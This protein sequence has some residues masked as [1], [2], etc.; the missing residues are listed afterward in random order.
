MLFSTTRCDCCSLPVGGT[1]DFCP[2]CG[3]PVDGAKE[4]QFLQSS[5]ASL[6]RVAVYGGAHMT[7][8]QLIE[9]YRARLHYLTQVKALPAGQTAQS[10]QKAPVAAVTPVSAPAAQQGNAPLPVAAGLAQTQSVPA[11]SASNQDVPGRSFSLG[12]FLE[13]QTITVVAALGAFLI[14]VGALSFVA[15]TPNL[16]LSFLVVFVVH[17][18][19]GVIGMI[20]YRYR[21]FRAVAVIYTAI[22]ALL[23]PLVGFSAY[24]VVSGSMLQ[25]STSTLVAIAALYAALAY[26]VL[27]VYQ[28]F[29]PFAYLAVVALALATLATASALRLGYWWWPGV[30]M[31]LALPA[32][33]SV[34]RVRGDMRPFVEPWTILREPLLVFM[35]ACVVACVVG[36]PSVFAYSLLLDVSNHART[37]VRLALSCMALLLFC[38]NFLLVWRTKRGMWAVALPYLFL[39][40]IL[41]GAY[42]LTFSRVGYV[43]T[44][45]GVALLYHGLTRFVPRVMQM[46]NG[47]KVHSEWL[48]LFLVALVPFLIMSPFLLVERA[49][50]SGFQKL[51]V[52][53]ETL[54][55]LSAVLLGL[56][57]TISVVFSHTG[58][59][60]VPQT[61]QAQWCW[62][63]LLSGF[64]LN[65]AFALFL[66]M[67]NAEPVWWL[68]GLSL[69]LV[70]TTILI[71]RF[72]SSTW[73]RPLDVLALVEIVLALLLGFNQRLELV[74]AMWLGVALLLYG[75][76]LY[77]RRAYV[78][79]LPVVFAALIIPALLL[80]PWVLSGA[81]ILLPL[82]AAGVYRF[83][84]RR[85]H[86]SSANAAPGGNASVIWEWPLLAI[87]VFYGAMLGLHDSLSLFSNSNSTAENWL[88]IPFLLN[89]EMAALALV[90]YG[91]AALARKKWWLLIVTG[92]AVAAVLVPG[93][94]LQVLLWL[95]PLLALLGLGVSRLAGKAWA[96]PLYTVAVVAA[97]LLG[98]MGYG[99]GQL[100]IT[101]TGLL[102]FAGLVYLI[103]VVERS[104]SGLWLGAGFAAWSV[105]Y[106]ELT[107]DLYRLSIVALACA[108]LGV[109]I[110][111]LR[112]LVPKLANTTGKNT[113]LRYALPLY[114]VA[115]V[116]AVLMGVYGV[117]IGVDA[118]FFA[119]VPT[120]M[121]IYALV[122]YGV[123]L[124]ERRA[125]WQWLVCLFAIW[126]MLLLPLAV[127]CTGGASGERTLTCSE[128]AQIILYYLAGCVLFTGIAGFLVGHIARRVTFKVSGAVVTGMRAR[129]AWNWSW[130]LVLLVAL[131]VVVAW[132]HSVGTLLPFAL[133]LSALGL[134]IG[135]TLLLTLLERVSE[136]L[137]VPIALAAWTLAQ[138]QWPL[139]WYLIAYSLLCML[140]FVA[141]FLRLPAATHIGTPSRLYRIVSIVGQALIVL[142]SIA[143]G[144]LSASVGLLAHIG[145][146]TLLVLAGLVFACGLVDADK[147]VRR[148]CNYSAGL[149]AALVCSWELSAFGLN[150]FDW[151][152]LPPAVY[153][154]VVAPFLARDA[155]LPRHRLWGQLCS[156]VG[157]LLLLLPILWISFNEGNLAPTLILAAEALGL[158][159]L[160]IITRIRI[161]VLSGA[162]L[163]VVA[164]MHALFLPSLG[165]PTSLAL[166][167]LGVTLLAIASVLS[168]A[169]RR[170]QSAWTGWQ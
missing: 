62:L 126:G 37:G 13:E 9:R 6:Q 118:P 87:G 64:L 41:S 110:G 89:L 98:V 19:F 119:A 91:A 161:F 127:S 57:L 155:T 134:F 27:A 22:F 158:L 58:W 39:L 146:G 24:R 125:S 42:T 131:L 86:V 97:V 73:A 129:F 111:C 170:I 67:L 52:S 25:F 84:T 150:H 164:A 141:Q 162:A 21:S 82:S 133:L 120:A 166:A 130:Y 148:V 92:F 93:T 151:L 32:I 29:S 48:A 149:L 20:S 147:T 76:A 80:S 107:G 71:R 138:M 165:I 40:C 105:F 104:L 152:T 85:W 5:L 90:W 54:A 95:A 117:L 51:P 115:C 35:L 74:L 81:S 139:E 137:L 2:R 124:F 157:A 169:R 128:Q 77:Q 43:L 94:S 65:A 143:H 30:A 154:V 17:A 1:G 123:I 7:V 49:Y 61:P 140:I 160:G 69:L 136:M 145:A 18:L 44:L 153:L 56:A 23:V 109:G 60:R 31:L 102:A 38:W 15:T 36:I 16:L 70:S 163:T 101:A 4:E 144:A 3:Y 108:V 10:E 103:A 75:V 46:F 11:Q 12:S 142:A 59:R 96:L 68:L 112:F 8:A 168:L 167:V 47:L 14:L 63:L 33:L 122:A 45:T 106:A 132:S 79:I 156:I 113:L 121:L 88:H 159:L 100:A 114:A 50:T 72:V 99:Q 55:G 53:W 26:G 34:P 28:K 66:L 135:V 116:A 83:I 78:L